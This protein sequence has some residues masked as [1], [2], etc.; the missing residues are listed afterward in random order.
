[1]EFLRFGSSIPGGYWGCCA[2][3]I[4]QNFK[5]DPSA[6]ASIEIVSGDGGNPVLGRDSKSLFAGPT[7]EDIFNA[8]LR[9]GTFSSDDMP[10]HVF[11]A[12]LTSDQIRSGYGKQWLAILKKNGFEFIRTTDNSVYTGASVVS[13]PGTYAKTSPHPNYLFGLFR[14]IGKGSIQDTRTPPKEWTD[15]TD[16]YDGDMSQDNVQTVQLRLWDDLG[17]AKLLSEA[18]IVA[19]GAPVT[20]AGRRREGAAPEPKA[21]RDQREGKKAKAADPFAHKAAF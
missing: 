4:I 1:M 13:K 16:P 11:L 6:K 14:N 18:E 7:Y 8:R 21:V 12:V 19:A 15:L 17:P 3:C 10:N 2:V 5:F 20:V 9:I